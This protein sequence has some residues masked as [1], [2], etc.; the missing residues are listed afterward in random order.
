M[1]SR[2]KV[3]PM[4]IATLEEVK[5]LE[6]GQPVTGISGV[7]GYVGDCENKTDRNGKSYSQQRIALKCGNGELSVTLYD[8]DTIDVSAKGKR[9]WILQG[10]DGRGQWGGLKAD[11][12][13]MTRGASAG[14]IRYGVTASAFAEIAWQEPGS[15]A[16]PAQQTQQAPPQ[17]QSSAPQQ[18]QQ[19]RP[20]GTM[21]LRGVKL[22]AAR[23]MIAADIC[24][25]AAIQVV[26]ANSADIA[27]VCGEGP[28]TRDVMALASTMFIQGQRESRFTGLGTNW[29]AYVGSAPAA[30]PT[31]P[32][33][34]PFKQEHLPSD[35]DGGPPPVDPDGEVP[36]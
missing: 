26:R 31:A 8:H 7:I 35:N 30:T 24:L 27:A 9:L 1:V 18:S 16:S 28:S 15:A 23:D 22:S 19:A 20:T 4:R 11:H 2:G 10:K 33:P 32:P 17:Q 34:A 25:K 21:D 36:F 14:Q 3:A 5:S 13:Q 6:R 29:T 12:F